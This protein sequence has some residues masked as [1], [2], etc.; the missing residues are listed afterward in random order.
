MFSHCIGAESLNWRK[1][2]CRSQLRK[3]PFLEA[4]LEDLH[5]KA[6]FLVDLYLAS[7]RLLKLKLFSLEL[8]E[9]TLELTKLVVHLDGVLYA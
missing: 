9:R 2:R 1:A 7:Q 6:D 8:L 4:I 3:N 5:L